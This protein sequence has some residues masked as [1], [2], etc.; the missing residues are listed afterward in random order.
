MAAPLAASKGWPVVKLDDHRTRPAEV[1]AQPSLTHK[2]GSDL[3]PIF[4]QHYFEIISLSCVVSVLRVTRPLEHTVEFDTAVNRVSRQFESPSVFFFEL[5][6]CRTDAR[7]FI[8]FFL[9][10]ITCTFRNVN[11][12]LN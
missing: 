12:Y 1:L 10:C 9:K 6:G 4:G 3:R 11:L 5:V 2:H 8:V 7:C